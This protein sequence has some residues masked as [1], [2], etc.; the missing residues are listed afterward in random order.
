MQCP[1]CRADVPDVEELRPRNLYVGAAPGCWAAYTELLGRQLS[2]PAL[3][4]A[5]MLS[6]DAYMAQHPGTPGRQSSQSVWVHLIGLCLSLEHGFDGVASARAKARVAA[7]NAEFTWLEPA[8]SLGP[9]TVLDVLATS[10]AEEHRTAVGAWAVSV[11]EAWGP[12][13]TSIRRRAEELLGP[14]RR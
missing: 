12:H 4:E 1:G 6:V 14:A 10:T 11:W 9:L 5:R 13:Q 7:P 3:A 2:D 8:E